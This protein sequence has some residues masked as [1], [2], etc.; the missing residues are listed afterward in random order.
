MED[1]DTK[2]SR[3]IFVL[4]VKTTCATAQRSNP[5]GKTHNFNNKSKAS[6]RPIAF[7]R[8]LLWFYVLCSRSDCMC[9]LRSL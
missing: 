4:V 7:A 2:H 9:Y 3:D 8:A 5:S 1:R 6:F